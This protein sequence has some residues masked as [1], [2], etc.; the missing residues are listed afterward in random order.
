MVTFDLRDVTR[1]TRN[2]ERVAKQIPFALAG[3]LNASAEIGRRE[4]IEHTWPGHVEARDP[5]F[6]KAALTSK[7]ERATKRRLRVVV[8]D[9][10]GRAH[11]RAH[12]VGGTKTPRGSAIAVPLDAIAEKRT[13]KGVPQRLK[14][15]A[16]PNSFVTDGRRPNTHLKQGAVYV[17]S[18][19][20]HKK[21]S[22]ISRTGKQRKDK[23]G[24]LASADSRKVT[25]AYVLKPSVP[26]RAAVPFHADFNRA[27]RSAMPREFRAAMRRAIATARK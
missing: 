14:P 20:Y 22:V 3:A 10:F 7:G 2:L 16:L 15:R 18:G 8:Y 24:K 5:N 19:Q 26:I 25:M 11:L 17:R 27:V 9:K 6:I 23:D 13:S 12:E 1:V 21:G 4:V